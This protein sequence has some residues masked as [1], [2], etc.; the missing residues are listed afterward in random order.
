MKLSKG[1]TNIAF[2]SDYLT[3]CDA[4]VLIILLNFFQ[5]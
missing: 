4:K 5:S 1:P 3:A 2:S